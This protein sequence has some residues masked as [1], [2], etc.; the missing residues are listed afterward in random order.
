MSQGAVPV[1]MFYQVVWQYDKYETCEEAKQPDLMTRIHTIHML[2]RAEHCGHSESKLSMRI[3]P[4]VPAREPTILLTDILNEL[5]IIASRFAD[6]WFDYN[7][8][9]GEAIPKPNLEKLLKTK[10]S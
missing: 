5:F 3:Q 4:G 10:K 7:T 2:D 6:T 8:T 1:M 9:T